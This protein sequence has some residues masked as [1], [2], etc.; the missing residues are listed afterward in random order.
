MKMIFNK[1][2]NKIENLFL[3]PWIVDGVVQTR[4]SV[5]LSFMLGVVVTFIIIYLIF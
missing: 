3:N 4:P 1:F 5:Q 2:I